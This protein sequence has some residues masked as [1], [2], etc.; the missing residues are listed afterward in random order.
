M[1]KTWYR[2]L[3]AF[4]IT[5]IVGVVPFFM[6][7]V[8]LAAR[9]QF[10]VAN[11]KAELGGEIVTA[12]L[13]A[14][15]AAGIPV[16]CETQ[17]K[18]YRDH[19]DPAD[20]QAWQ[21]V[22]SKVDTPE[23]RA[24]VFDFIRKL[25]D[26]EALAFGIAEEE[27]P[28]PLDENAK[29]RKILAETADLRKEIRRLARKRVPV[30]FPIQFVPMITELN[31]L[32]AFGTAAYLVE[33]ESDEAIQAGNSTEIVDSAFTQIDLATAVGGDASLISQLTVSKYRRKGIVAMKVA[34]EKNLID[35][36]DLERLA[37]QL[38]ESPLP[39]NRFR[40]AMRS[41]RASVLPIFFAPSKYLIGADGKM[42]K[43]YQAAAQDVLHYLDFM[44]RIENLEQL[45]L[46][47]VDE[48]FLLLIS[49]LENA[50]DNLSKL[51]SREWAFTVLALKDLLPNYRGIFP[52]FSLDRQ[53][54]N[55]TLHGI[56]IRRYQKKFGE[57][58]KDLDSLKEV[59][60]DAAEYM[61]PGQFPMGY[62]L[63]EDGA[64]LWST[65]PWFG[66]E[67]T[68][69]PITPDLVTQHI[70]ETQSCYWKFAP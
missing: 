62:R 42:S 48:Q 17:D 66:S 61:P 11:A 30:Q 33:L 6:L 10:A 31:H 8:W 67:T 5:A 69:D 2:V 47:E 49:E 25:P 64:I 21:E 15:R 65:P 37:S 32:S 24:A 51:R 60:F 40:D 52:I 12:K 63:E 38:L 39:T 22:I 50:R 23:F 18:W 3:V 7:T 45:P 55:M 70:P 9:Y 13:D 54:L 29:R 19:T 27:E 57:F 20:A 53:L 56:A 68:A 36:A 16:D 35:E 34:L 4:A 43:D 14:L 26:P 41:D 46:S 58:P 44:E 28:E 59:G 1:F